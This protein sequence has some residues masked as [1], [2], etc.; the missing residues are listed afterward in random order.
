MV[1]I[2]MFPITIGNTDGTYLTT[3]FIPFTSIIHLF[4]KGFNIILK[5]IVGNIII[6]IPL[7]LLLPVISNKIKTF[8]HVFISGFLFSLSIEISQYLLSIFN[9][10]D[11]TTIDIDDLILNTFGTIIG[12]IVMKYITKTKNEDSC[13]EHSKT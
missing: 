1:A 3:N 5:Q 4:S 6:F 7:G 11:F 8:L 10:K 13:I 2:T 9:L 12:F